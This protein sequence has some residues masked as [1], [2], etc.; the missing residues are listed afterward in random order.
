MKP[1]QIKGEKGKKIKI[2]WSCGVKP[3]C[4]HKTKLGVWLHIWITKL[5]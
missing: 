1:K 3:F 2:A 5:K 4:E